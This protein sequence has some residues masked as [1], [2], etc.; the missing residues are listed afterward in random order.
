[1]LLNVPDRKEILMHAANKALL[2][3][4]G[5]IAP[6]SEIIKPGYGNKSKA[7]LKKLIAEVLEAQK[8]EDNYLI[9]KKK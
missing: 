3:L 6:V 8:Q 4:K 2:E 1:M 7:A 5:C 9:I